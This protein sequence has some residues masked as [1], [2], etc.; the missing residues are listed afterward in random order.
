MGRKPSNPGAIPRFRPRTRGKVTYYYY[1]HGGKPRV[2]TPLGCDYGLAIKAW[3]AIE[4]ATNL[5]A[6]AVLTFRYVAD[7]YMVEVAPNKSSRTYADNRAE[8]KRLLTFF[9]DPPAPLDAIKPLNVRQYMD[10][11]KAKVRANR[12]KALLS[13]IWNFARNKGYTELPNPCA[14]IKGNPEPGRN[15]Y[16]E[17]SE[18]LAIWTVA[19]E[20]LRDAMDLA[21]LTGQRPADVLRLAIT[22]VR[23]GAIQMQQ[24]KTGAKLRIEVAGE[25]AAV[26]AR[27]MARKATHKVYSTRLIV[28]EYGRPF[29]VHALSARFQKACAVAGVI[30]IQFRDL[31]AKAATDKAESAGDVRQAQRQLGHA[32]VVMTE[33]Y[34]RARRGDK[35]T[36]TR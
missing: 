1:D 8:V 10:W 20:V 25:L 15:V 18:Y 19:D 30:G 4:H 33:T 29:G 12:E 3:A 31:R 11:R 9:D 36:P 7:R 28:N 26:V 13:S 5:P 34:I 16:V 23:N 35:V 17:E 24:A 6:P 32:S 21:Y 27:I 22:D 14:G 2:E